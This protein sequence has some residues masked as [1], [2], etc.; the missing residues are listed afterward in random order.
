[1]TK[2]EVQSQINE[3]EINDYSSYANEE[4]NC[5]TKNFTDSYFMTGDNKSNEIRTESIGN[6]C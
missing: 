4:S 3:I 1:M 5:K 2:A 6:K